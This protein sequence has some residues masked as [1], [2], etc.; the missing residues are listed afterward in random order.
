MII[1]SGSIDPQMPDKIKGLGADE[2]LSKPVD[3]AAL[4]DALDKVLMQS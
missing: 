2:F 4:Y 1:L 3:A